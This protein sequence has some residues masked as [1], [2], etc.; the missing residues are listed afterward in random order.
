[1]WLSMWLGLQGHMLAMLSLRNESF[2]R[3]TCPL[4]SRQTTGA[5]RLGE[6]GF[7]AGSRRWRRRRRRPT[8]PAGH[9]TSMSAS[10]HEEEK[11]QTEAGARPSRWRKSRGHHDDSDLPGACG[12]AGEAVGSL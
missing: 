1:M 3:T 10:A 4:P 2:Q 9:A 7:N 11:T 8:K 6:L 5:G 12:T